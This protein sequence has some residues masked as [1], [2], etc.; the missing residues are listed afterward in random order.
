MNPGEY[1]RM[2]RLE[3]RHWWFV[4]RRDLLCRAL[5][6][7]PPPRREGGAAP[8]RLLDVGCGTG[9]TLDRLRA[10]GMAVTGIDTEPLALARCRTR[11]HGRL[12]L[13]SAEALPF[14]AQSFDAAV[15][16]DVL[17]HVA[18]DAAACREI[19]RL[20]VPGGLFMASVPAYR[21]LWGEHDIALMHRRRYV[22]REVRALL[23]TAGLRPL[24]MT[25]VVSALLPVAWAVRQVR[26]LR[27]RRSGE[28]PRSD[29]VLPRSAL[30]N[31]LLVLGLGW[32][33][34]AALRTPIPF[35]LSVF[36]VARKQ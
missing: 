35:G 6:R 32:E 17:E 24:H 33:G 31:D 27:A 13:A 36:V 5:T 4:A 7:F 14:P 18:D 12:I 34:R 8:P 11:G 10:L 29:T 19:A 2:Y 21:A 15:A 25:Y 30:I 16:M 9:A 28:P 3:D 23:E 1:E 20:L 22:A 26:R